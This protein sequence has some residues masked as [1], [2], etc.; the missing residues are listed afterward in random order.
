[1]MKSISKLTAVIRPMIKCEIDTQWDNF[2]QEVKWT[3]AICYQFSTLFVFGLGHVHH[4]PHA[5]LQ[6]KDTDCLPKGSQ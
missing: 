4:I 6:Q 1:M 5:L 2:R 3:L